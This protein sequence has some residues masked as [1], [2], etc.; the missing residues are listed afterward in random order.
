MT[1]HNFVPLYLPACIYHLFMLQVPPTHYNIQ[2]STP[3]IMPS[4]MP[5][6]TSSLVYKT[7]SFYKTTCKSSPLTSLPW[8]LEAELREHSLLALIL[9]FAFM[10]LEILKI[11]QL[12][13]CVFFFFRIS[14]NLDLSNISSWLYLDYVFLVRLS[15]YILFIKFYQLPKSI[16]PI[17][18][19]I[20]FVFL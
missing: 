15:H 6:M 12:C 8:R 19:V 2:D 3:L 17:T 11:G 20:H 1:L 9:C 14:F 7:T 10:I 13:V 16:C 4:P 18:N 5:K